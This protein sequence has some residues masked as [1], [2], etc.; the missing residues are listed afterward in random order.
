MAATTNLPR[1]FKAIGVFFFFGASLAF[2]AGATLV[3]PG[4]VLD[5]IWVLNKFAFKQLA[6]LGRTVGIAFLLLGVALAAAGTG[7]LRRRRW[8]WGLAAAI[9]ASQVLGSLV[10]AFRGEWLGGATGVLI[11]GTLLVYLIGPRVRDAF[12]ETAATGQ[13]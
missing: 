8:G 10:N 6:P 13:N 1:G 3:W 9:V 2:L 5:S 11:A 7:W 4:T 12:G